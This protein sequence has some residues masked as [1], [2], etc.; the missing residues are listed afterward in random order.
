MLDNNILTFA[1]NILPLKAP[2]DSG[3]TAYAT[4]YVN[5]T[6]V[7]HA[8]FLV[9]FGVITAASADQDIIVTVEASTAAASNATEVNIPFKWRLSGAT[10]AN[11]WGA[12]TTAVAANGVTIDTVN[13]DGKLLLIDVDPAVIEATHGQR[14]AKYVRVV[15]GID[16]GGTATFNSVVA[17]LA[18][19]YPQATHLSAT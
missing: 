1:E 2:V 19:R 13:D 12:V 5:M 4:P 18:P 3:G 17:L 6:N 14:D 11:T 16:A 10:G 15:V 8:T 9:Y 7:L